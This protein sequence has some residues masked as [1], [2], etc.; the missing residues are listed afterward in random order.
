M[1]DNIVVYNQIGSLVVPK[2][3]ECHKKQNIFSLAWSNSLSVD[4]LTSWMSRK[5]KRS[6]CMKIIFVSVEYMLVPYIM[7][8]TC[9]PLRNILS[10]PYP[11]NIGASV[12]LW[13]IIL[14]LSMAG[15]ESGKPLESFLCGEGRI[16]RVNLLQGRRFC[17]VIH[18]YQDLHTLAKR[19]PNSVRPGP[20]EKC[21]K[22]FKKSD[23]NVLTPV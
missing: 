3:I 11:F 20:R 8:R 7:K 2:N 5:F 13:R 16:R 19:H 15:G 4:S 12:T 21:I 23:G 17:F 10:T 9:R 6:H 18:E 22:S 1:Q 14:S